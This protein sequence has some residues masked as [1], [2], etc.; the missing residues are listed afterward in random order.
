[1]KLKDKIRVLLFKILGQKNVDDLRYFKFVH[2]FGRFS[3][4]KDKEAF[5]RKFSQFYE[6]EMAVI[7]KILNN[8]NVIIDVGAN[9]GPYSFFLSKIYPDAKIFAFEPATRSYNIFKKIIKRFGLD[10]VI[11]VKKGLG[12]K[13]EDKEIVMPAQYTILAYVS[14]ENTKKNKEDQIEKIKITTIDS[15]VKRNKIKKIDFIKCDVEGFE[16]SVFN[17]AKNSLKKFKPTVLVE[18]EERHTKKYD[19][20]PQE[21]ISFFKKIG[22]SC[23]SVKNEEIKLADKIVKEIP[24]YIFST[25]KIL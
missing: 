13:E 9:Y 20:N 22:Y 17:G 1:M 12:L 10:N 4:I 21:V 2:K 3:K 16:L 23:Y 8:P 14:A 5:I 11:P 25:R 15:F 7:P 24:L 6:L 18:I 19:I